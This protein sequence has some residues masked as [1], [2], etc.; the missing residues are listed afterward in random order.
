[1]SANIQLFV[2][3][4]KKNTK[5][6]SILLFTINQLEKRHKQHRKKIRNCETEGYENLR[7]IR[8]ST[9]NVTERH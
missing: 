1:M 3:H 8:S 7:Y 9:G 4:D 2:D 5:I 6:L